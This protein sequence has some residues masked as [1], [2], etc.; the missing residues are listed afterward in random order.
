MR[1]FTPSAEGIRPV[2]EQNNSFNKKK[3]NAL[4]LSFLNDPN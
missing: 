2:Y 3:F 4:K 1:V